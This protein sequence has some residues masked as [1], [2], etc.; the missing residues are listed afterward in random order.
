MTEPA[1]E[2]EYDPPQ[3]LQRLPSWLAAQVARRAH[4]L[5]EEALAHEGARRQHFVVL[6][7]L[8]EQ[9][10]ASQAALGRRLWIDR[11]D[12]H[13]ILNEL[14]AAGQVARRRDDVDRR[15]NVVVLTRRGR[16]ALGRLDDRV[17]AAQEKLLASLTMPERRQLR[18]LLERVVTGDEA[19]SA[20]ASS[21]RSTSAARL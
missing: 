17:D 4:R 3:R 21:S 7:S 12:L 6:T 10:P 2:T 5:V 20:T 14:E 19:S 8:A 11:S 9:G 1:P 18:G 13:A 16:A 15:R